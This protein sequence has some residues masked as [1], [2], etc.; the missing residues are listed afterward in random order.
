MFN[1]MQRFY[2]HSENQNVFNIQGGGMRD[3]CMRICL[4]L[5]QGFRLFIADANFFVQALVL[6]VLLC[7]DS[8]QTRHNITLLSS[9]R[10]FQTVPLSVCLPYLKC[11]GQNCNVGVR[12]I[13][14]KTQGHKLLWSPSVFTFMCHW[15]LSCHREHKYIGRSPHLAGYVWPR[16]SIWFLDEFLCSWKMLMICIHYT[17]Q[18]TKWIV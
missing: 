18:K 9:E 10:C 15:V 8:Q 3:G 7:F 17:N 2:C 1:W 11:W 4:F 13:F 16:R 5:Y 6:I 14:L 12:A